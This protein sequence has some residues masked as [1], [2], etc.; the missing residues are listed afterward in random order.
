[1]KTLIQSAAIALLAATLA[2]P[3]LAV[4][5]KA[6]DSS[7]VKAAARDGQ[8]NREQR[9]QNQQN[10][11]NREERAQNQQN[12]QNRQERQNRRDR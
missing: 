9:A 2:V 1:M 11:Q 5:Q 3:A 6:D 12:R 4:V 8:Q 10:R 7:I